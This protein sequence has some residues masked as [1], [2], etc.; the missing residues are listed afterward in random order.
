MTNRKIV[1][2]SPGEGRKIIVKEPVGADITMIIDG[3]T[4]GAEYLSEGIT[5]I[6]PGITLKPAHSHK[7]IEEIIYVLEGQGEVWIEGQTCKIKKGDSVLF[8]AN[9]VHT[10]RNIGSGELALLCIFSTA[11]YRE[12][13][14]YRKHED[15]DLE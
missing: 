5:R 14:A 4:N 12:E 13:G 8:P 1:K 7:D 10:T 6:K 15:I 11:Q 9:I 2:I 3:H